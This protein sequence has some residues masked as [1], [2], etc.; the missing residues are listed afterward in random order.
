MPKKQ[1]EDDLI[2]ASNGSAPDEVGG[3][4]VCEARST[5]SHRRVCWYYP[6]TN[7]CVP[8]RTVVVNSASYVLEHER[9][10]E[11]P[12]RDSRRFGRR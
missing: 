8:H 7:Q 10:L 9:D 5:E 1:C 6:I 12:E 2:L 3:I 11:G 4:R